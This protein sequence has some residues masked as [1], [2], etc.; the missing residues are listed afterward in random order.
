VVDLEGAFPTNN[1]TMLLDAD[2]SSKEE[3][4]DGLING[5]TRL[6]IRVVVFCL[7]YDSLLAIKSANSSSNST[8]SDGLA[9]QA[10]VPTLLAL[11]SLDPALRN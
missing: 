2:L 7:A 1:N 9:I 10:V 8:V 11:K 4:M 3:M 5:S 6:C